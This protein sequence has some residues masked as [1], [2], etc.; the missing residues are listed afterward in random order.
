MPRIDSRLVYL[1]HVVWRGEELFAAVCANDLE[2]IVAKWKHGR[3]QG[4]AH[5]T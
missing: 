5:E 1:D 4:A 3:Y 2:G